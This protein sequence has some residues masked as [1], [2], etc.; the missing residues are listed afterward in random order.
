[1]SPG[2]TS[3]GPL[4]P[5]TN[6]KTPHGQHS[7]ES[8]SKQA[9]N[10]INIHPSQKANNFKSLNLKES[11]GQRAKERERAYQW[12]VAV[13]PDCP[14]LASS[15]PRLGSRPREALSSGP[16]L[17]VWGVEARARV[18]ACADLLQQEPNQPIGGRGWWIGGR[19]DGRVPIYFRSLSLS[20]SWQF[21]NLSMCF[22]LICWAD[23]FK[24]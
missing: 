8:T 1:M 12:A 15:P 10:K 20:L 14:V 18:Q 16:R 19:G 3:H 4:G 17:Q 23:L 11:H 9:T 24:K 21:F 2:T 13:G 5:L 7:A 22:G 6:T